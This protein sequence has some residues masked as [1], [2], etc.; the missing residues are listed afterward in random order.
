L[1]AGV[2]NWS[3]GAVRLSNI[4]PL[5]LSN[6]ALISIHLDLNLVRY[7]R[8][9][10]AHVRLNWEKPRNDGSTYD[11]AHGYDKLCRNREKRKEILF[12]ERDLPAQT[13]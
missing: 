6:H 10:K 1:I 8:T 5:N 2:H 11:Y 7:D 3:S 9:N 4:T 13:E 12:Q